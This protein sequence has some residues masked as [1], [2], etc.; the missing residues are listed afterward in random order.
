MT[1]NPNENASVVPKKPSIWSKE[2]DEILI[3]K[4]KDFGYKNWASV[5][6]FIPGRSAIQCSA[7]Y[8]RIQPGLIKGAWTDEEDKELLRLYNYYGKNWSCISKSMPQRTGKQIRDRFLNA[9]DN[10]LKKE[11]LSFEENKKIIKWYKIFGNSW[12]K[13]A[14]KLKGRTGDMV[15]NRFY[16]S[17]KNHLD[18]YDDIIDEKGKR[19]KRKYK[20]RNKTNKDI[21]TGKR[22]KRKYIK[23]TKEDTNIQNSLE[24]IKSN[25]ENSTA[26][27]QKSE[28]PQKEELTKQTTQPDMLLSSKTISDDRTFSNLFP[29]PFNMSSNST[30]KM[31]LS[32]NLTNKNIPLLRNNSSAMLRMQSSIDTT[33]VNQ[34]DEYD[35]SYVIS[36]NKSFTKPLSLLNYRNEGINVYNEESLKMKSEKLKVLIN[37]QMINGMK[38]DNLLQ[39]LKILQELKTITNEKMNLLSMGN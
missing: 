28:A 22:I 1:D 38:K 25:S 37:N 5:A 16:S 36:D 24:N 10:K 14:K 32:M 9:L 27:N 13:I 23:K 18:D 31:P 39:Q 35:N 30:I 21:T 26:T 7:R 29:L 3:V 8:K 20:K 19:K 34:I 17:L 15:K 12:S 4:A 6:S 11:K 33:N 2:E